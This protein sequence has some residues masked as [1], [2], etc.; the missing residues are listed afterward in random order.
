MSSGL[1]KSS[2]YQNRP[3]YLE[4]RIYRPLKDTGEF[5]SASRAK[6]TALE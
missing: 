4:S 5:G 3:N 1:G 2:D 6:R